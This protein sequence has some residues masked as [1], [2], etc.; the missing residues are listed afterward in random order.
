MRMDSYPRAKRQETGPD[1]PHSYR[2]R[3]HRC[4]SV[5]DVAAPRREGRPASIPAASTIPPRAERA[6]GMLGGAGHQDSAARAG[7]G[8]AA[9]RR[10]PPRI[11]TTTQFAMTTS[12]LQDL[13]SARR[14]PRCPDPRPLTSRRLDGEVPGPTSER[15][16]PCTALT[17]RWQRLVWATPYD[18]RPKRWKEDVRREPGA[19]RGRQFGS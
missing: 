4:A 13:G 6:G 9:N 3:E 14:G 10:F 11:R 8:D 16:L 2:L 5:R 7:A 19:D 12:L 17:R 18:T 1:D 15:L